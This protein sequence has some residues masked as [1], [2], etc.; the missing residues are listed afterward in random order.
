M[1]MLKKFCNPPPEK[2][3]E[4]TEEELG[5]QPRKILILEDD[6]T[7]IEVLRPFLES[8]S[9]LVKTAE[10]GVEGLKKTMAEDFDIIL[11]DMLM[12]NLPGDM[13][14][15]A[16]NRTKPHLCKRF[17]FMTGYKG[18]PRWDSFVRQIGG[19][20]LWKPFELHVL[21]E[22]IQLVLRKTQAQSA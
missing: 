16:V 17:I 8:Q 14:Y 19:I 7:H 12:P 6:A 21:L 9:F 13:F 4:V 18:D 1:A 22:T 5:P 10:N 20:M 11:C 3:H 2:V 15:L